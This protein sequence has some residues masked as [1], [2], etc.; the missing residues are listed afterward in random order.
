MNDNVATVGAYITGIIM[1]LIIVA[2][3][4]LIARMIINAVVRIKVARYTG[5]DPGA[6]PRK[7]SEQKSER[8]PA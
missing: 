8:P 6:K 3:L 7:D 4:V 2:G 5:V 1:V